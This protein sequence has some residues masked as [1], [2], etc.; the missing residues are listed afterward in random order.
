MTLPPNFSLSLSSLD[1]RKSVKELTEGYSFTG[2]SIMYNINSGV[3]YVGRPAEPPPY[4]EVIAEP[5]REGPPPPYM[6]CENLIV[7]QANPRFIETE[8]ATAINTFAPTVSLVN[9][10]DDAVNNQSDTD[11]R[12]VESS[13]DAI[14]SQNFVPNVPGPQVASCQTSVFQA[15]GTNCDGNMTACRTK[16]LQSRDSV[17]A[18]LVRVGSRRMSAYEYLETDALLSGNSNVPGIHSAKTI[19]WK[20]YS[21]HALMKSRWLNSDRNDKVM[22]KH[23]YRQRIEKAAE[24]SSLK[25]SEN[26]GVF[27]ETDQQETSTCI[28]SAPSE[29]DVAAGFSSA[30]VNMTKTQKESETSDKSV[31]P[32]C[33]SSNEASSSHTRDTKLTD[34]RK[35]SEVSS[36]K[37][38]RISE[39]KLSSDDQTKIDKTSERISQTSADTSFNQVVKRQSSISHDEIRPKNLNESSASEVVEANSQ[40][41]DASSLVLPLRESFI[42]VQRDS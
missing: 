34:Y 21:R 18:P 23:W 19:A 32:S 26:E 15:L 6:S 2:V 39:G 36:G 8:I 27:L 13:E 31:V 40:T 17:D 37:K 25:D 24:T 35:N 5:P 28:E 30:F 41:R 1:F 10:P 38:L 3:Q 22:D 11:I 33:S 20:P 14:D 29:I 12:T 4:S 9:L 16:S 7:R 42:G